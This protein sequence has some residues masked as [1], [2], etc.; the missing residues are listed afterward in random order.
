VYRQFSETGFV[1]MCSSLI[2]RA[3]KSFRF[4]CEHQQREGAK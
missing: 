1:R 3:E 4:S 2:V